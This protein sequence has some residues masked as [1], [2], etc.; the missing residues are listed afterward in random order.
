MVDTSTIGPC[1]ENAVTN[2]ADIALRDEIDDFLSRFDSESWNLKLITEFSREG[3]TLARKIDVNGGIARLF[4]CLSDQALVTYFLA[5]RSKVKKQ[6]EAELERRNIQSLVATRVVETTERADLEEREL[7][8]KNMA[9]QIEEI[10]PDGNYKRGE[11]P[12]QK[13][14]NR[15]NNIPNCP[16]LLIS[17]FSTEYL[18]K[19]YALDTDL[20]KAASEELLRRK[21]IIIADSEVVEEHVKKK[22]IAK[23]ANRIAR[24][25]L[26]LNDPN[27]RPKSI[28]DVDI[29]LY[30]LMSEMGGFEVIIKYLRDSL[31]LLI[32]TTNYTPY[33]E[34]IAEELK[35]RNTGIDSKLTPDVSAGV[36][37]VGKL[38][39]KI[40]HRKQW[41]FDDIPESLRIRLVRYFGKIEFSIRYFKPELLLRFV[42]SND[43]EEGILNKQVSQYICEEVNKFAAKESEWSYYDLSEELKVLIRKYFKSIPEFIEILDSEALEN[44]VFEDKDT[45]IIVFRRKFFL[46]KSRYPTE[47]EVNLYLA[48]LELI[49]RPKT[50]EECRGTARP[51]QF[52]TCKFHMLT[53]FA[54]NKKSKLTLEYLLE[55]Q[56]TCILDI[57]EDNPKGLVMEEVGKIFG[58]SKQRVLQIQIAA[59]EKMD[60]SVLRGFVEF[61]EFD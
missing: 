4:Y 61:D 20:L 17:R 24:L 60:S 32:E 55:M 7:E 59:R 23:T 36:E 39:K 42:P 33:A 38:T 18:E 40:G 46:Q 19:F 6:L 58:F 56:H 27:F 10:F 53:A 5:P 2:P 37:L 52:V 50:I 15:I 44:L 22:R 35:I 31:L 1:S 14:Q 3:Q 48:S 12:D 45:Q 13:L 54:G 34:L 28:K 43:E 26:S 16:L 9:K 30:N 47:E 49:D 57:V 8:L 25:V 41:S 51:C 11:I 21:S 29:R